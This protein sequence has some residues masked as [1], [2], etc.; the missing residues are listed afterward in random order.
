MHLCPRLLMLLLFTIIF[1]SQKCRCYTME[2]AR[3]EPEKFRDFVD[4]AGFNR[5]YH[6][7][8]ALITLYFLLSSIVGSVNLVSHVLGRKPR[9]QI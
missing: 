9:R 8:I 4:V 3:T 6:A 1:F 5:W 2:E 7:G